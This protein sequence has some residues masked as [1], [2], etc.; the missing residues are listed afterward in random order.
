MRAGAAL[1]AGALSVVLIAFAL[2]AAVVVN[3]RRPAVLAQKLRPGARE[4]IRKLIDS[5]SM[6]CHCEKGKKCDCAAKAA[7]D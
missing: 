7:N 3:E 6:E 4:A 1:G 2:M 5:Y